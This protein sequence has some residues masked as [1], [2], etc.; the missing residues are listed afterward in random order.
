VF[1]GHEEAGVRGTEGRDGNALDP[2]RE[3]PSGDLQ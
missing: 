2:E 3:R 1:G